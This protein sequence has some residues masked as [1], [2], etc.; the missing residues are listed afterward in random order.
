[1]FRA[2]TWHSATGRM[3]SQAG[4]MRE[5]DVSRRFRQAL[6]MSLVIVPSLLLIAC[7]DYQTENRTG[8]FLERTYKRQYTLSWENDTE[9][10]YEEFCNTAIDVCYVSDRELKRGFLAFTEFLQSISGGNGCGSYQ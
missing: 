4:K 2:R 7:R 9:P 8:A 10:I 1:M 3:T 6:A 5:T